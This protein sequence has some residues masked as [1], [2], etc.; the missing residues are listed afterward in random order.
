ML[1]TLENTKQYLR[2]DSHDEDD[3][4]TKLIMLSEKMIQDIGRTDFS[5]CKENPELIESAILYAVGYLY[6]HREEC[7]HK[8]LT[9][10]LKYMLF[11]VREERF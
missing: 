4:I 9:E 11:Q 7:D 8:K 1:V 5:I 6:E 3:Y 10:T 2:V